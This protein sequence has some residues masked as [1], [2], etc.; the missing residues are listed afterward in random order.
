MFD[1]CVLRKQVDYVQSRASRRR[2]MQSMDHSP[3]LSVSLS[4]EDWD[5]AT[6]Q[7]LALPFPDKVWDVVD[8]IVEAVIKEGIRPS[9]RRLPLIGKIVRAYAYCQGAKEVAVEHLDVLAHMLWM[10]PEGSHDMASIRNRPPRKLPKPGVRL[11]ADALRIEHRG[12][13]IPF[14]NNRSLT[15]GPYL[16]GGAPAQC[17]FCMQKFDG[18]AWHGHDDKYYCTEFC[19]DE[20]ESAATVEQRARRAS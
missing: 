8:S 1:R 12:R 6:K 13:V 16:N 9:D 2:L 5:L 4:L 11:D 20:A 18:Y 14:G 3:K 17:A 7:A 10:N 15:M 19:S